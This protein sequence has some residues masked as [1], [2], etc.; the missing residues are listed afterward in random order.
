MTT[1]ESVDS[2]A[3]IHAFTKRVSIGTLVFEDGRCRLVERGLAGLLRGAS[4]VTRKHVGRVL[5]SIRR[6]IALGVEPTPPSAQV[7][8]RKLSDA[9]AKQA[10][11]GPRPPASSGPPVMKH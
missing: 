6:K 4:P 8:F 11:A 10:L 1:V 9:K 2:V 7:F 3:D 5:T